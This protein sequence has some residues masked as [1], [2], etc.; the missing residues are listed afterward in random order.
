M[1][2]DRRNFLKTLAIGSAAQLISAKSRG[3][4]GLYSQTSHDQIASIAHD[5]LRPEFHLLPPHNWMN[6]PNG[7]IWWKGQYHLFYQLNPHA[8]VWGDMHWGHAISPDM[9]HWKHQPIALAPTPGGADSEGCFSGSAVVLDGKPAFIYTGVQ[10]APPAETTL[11]DGNDKL[12]ETQML[13]IAEDS[14]LLRWKKIES[15]VIATPPQGM[16]VTG[17]RDP[18]PWREGDAWYLGIGSGE[19]TI[20]GCVLLYRSHDLRHWEYLHKL[21]QGKPNGKVA[22]NPCDSGEMWECPDF[23][24]VSG[25]HC[26]LYSSEDKVFWTTGEYDAQQHR[27]TA[28]RTGVLDHGSAF[29][30][31]KSFLA[32]D[33]RRILWG[34]IRETRPEAQ[35]AAAGWSGAMGLPR[36]LT[37]NSEGQLEMNPAAETAKL[38][39]PAESAELKAET[40]CKQTLATLRRELL[41]PLDHAK[42]KISIRLSTTGKA[43][44]ELLIDVPASL[45]TCGDITFAL[46]PTLRPD[47]ALRIFIDGSVIECFF[48][49]RECLTSR[50]YEVRPGDTELEI[51]LLAG[52]SFRV[53]QWPLEAIS[54]DRLTT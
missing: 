10:N 30:A 40:P 43:I 6:D 45:V 22:V 33:N 1:K 29:Y 20:G 41:I 28:T 51:S 4:R 5:P 18:C 7:P 42:P 49:G 14:H 19:R 13:A 53:T 50:V 39:G 24:S 26:L 54:P 38:R 31:P 48:A 2:Q 46:P 21:A 8:A 16:V 12:R 15:P 47:D 36:V 44:W 52:E 27:Y 25:Q 34:W 9:I 17:F 23:F 35:F 37:I 32:P 11:H 3:A